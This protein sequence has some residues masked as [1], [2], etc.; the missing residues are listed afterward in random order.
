MPEKGLF[1]LGIF[2][3]ET[4]EFNLKE[5]K[6]WQ[7]LKMISEHPGEPIPMIPPDLYPDD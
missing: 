7:Y 2:Q 6:Y 3:P 4:P 1:N 5:D